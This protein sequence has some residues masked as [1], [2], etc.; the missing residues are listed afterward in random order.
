M[1]GLQVAALLYMSEPAASLPNTSTS[2]PGGTE[3]G[4]KDA[5]A[6]FG[7]ELDSVESVEEA[8]M[9]EARKKELRG[10]V[11]QELLQTSKRKGPPHQMSQHGEYSGWVWTMPE[12]RY[13]FALPKTSAPFPF[14]RQSHVTLQLYTGTCS[15]HH[16]RNWFLHL[17]VLHAELWAA[18][19]QVMHTNTSHCLSAAAS[20]HNL[21]SHRTNCVVCVNFCTPYRHA[22]DSLPCQV[23]SRLCLQQLITSPS[24]CFMLWLLLL[25]VATIIVGPKSPWSTTADAR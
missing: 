3:P 2:L 19:T 13:P 14:P 15:F 1:H 5:S 21:G 11:I 25:D 12:T 17:C 18:M 8:F 7:A 16:C 24:A 22:Q 23:R 4:F 6:S 10:L 9:D 20:M